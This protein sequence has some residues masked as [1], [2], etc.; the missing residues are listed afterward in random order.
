MKNR[1][2]HLKMLLAEALPIYCKGNVVDVGSGHAKYGS[3][4][5]KYASSYTT[6]DNL[7]SEYQFGE[8]EAFKPDVTSSVDRMP[9]QN[10]EFDTAVC[11][12]V[13]EHVEE[14][15]VVVAEIARILK[16]GGHALM[17]SGWISPYHKEPDD[18]W[19]FSA[20]T[21]KLM[22]ER[23]GMEVVATYKKGGLVTVLLYIISRNISLNS[24][25]R[26]LKRFWAKVSP[27]LELC[28]EKLDPHF[29]TEDT[30]GHL[31]V[32]RKK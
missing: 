3:M 16:P 6:V 19:R 9:F 4:I 29:P 13:L 8:G 11:T 21:Y 5:K 14:P 27:Y 18:Y 25:K 32:A 7:S 2:A 28:A 1:K 17:S 20:S 24:K 30:I 23:A 10:D 12:E 31:V 15:Y 26:W 22:C